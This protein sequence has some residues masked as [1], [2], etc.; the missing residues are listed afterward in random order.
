MME[1]WHA[2]RLPLRRMSPRFAQARWPLGG[3]IASRRH[4]RDIRAAS[5]HPRVAR[6]GVA[7]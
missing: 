1:F 4:V 6:Q 7:S 3:A 5:H 2:W